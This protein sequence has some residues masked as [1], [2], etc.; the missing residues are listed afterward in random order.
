MS[1]IRARLVKVSCLICPCPISMLEKMG[2]SG[3]AMRFV[4]V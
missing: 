2:D 4:S 1:F 3:E